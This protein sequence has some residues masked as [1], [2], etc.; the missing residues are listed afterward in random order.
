MLNLTRVTTLH[1]SLT[2]AQFSLSASLNLFSR[3]SQYISLS[4]RRFTSSQMLDMAEE[5]LKPGATL[6]GQSGRIYTIQE[7]L[8][9]RR[10]PLLCVY[11][12]GAEGKNFIVKNMIPGEYEYQQDLQKPLSSSPHLRTVIDGLPG[13]EIFIYPYLQTD[14]LQFSQKNLSDATRKAMLK[15]ALAGLADMHDRN[16]IH[17][18]IKP[19]NI[20][21]DYEETDGVFSIKKINISDLEDSVILPPGKYLRKALCGNQMWRSPES[22]ARAA[23]GTPSDIFSFGIVSIYVVLKDMVFRCTEEELAADDSWRYVLKRH[24][25]LF[26]NEDGFKGLLQWIGEENPFFERLIT[27]AA[28]FDKEG[29]PR[30]PFE[31]R[32]YVDAEFR[33]L[34]GRMTNLDPAKRITAREAL[35]HPWF[36]ENV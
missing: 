5:P 32:H 17:T 10:K 34:V 6:C 25:S 33:D 1:R 3:P 12:A 2:T 24:I 13:P 27:L 35:E 31:L 26:A 20:L 14:F 22:W 7:V 36:K 18:D 29:E 23:Q 30:R 15:S 4:S 28:N 19:N 8:A 16:I 11:R 9:E 21:L